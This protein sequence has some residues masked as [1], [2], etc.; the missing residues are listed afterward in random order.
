V[1]ML[2]ECSGPQFHLR[3]TTVP[4]PSRKTRKEGV[5]IIKGCR[6]GTAAVVCEETTKAQRKAFELAE[7]LGGLLTERAA[8]LARAQLLTVERRAEISR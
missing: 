6:V 3:A 7:L 2:A 4:Q 5:R 1:V 8:C